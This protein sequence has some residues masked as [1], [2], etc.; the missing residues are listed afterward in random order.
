MAKYLLRNV[1]FC[2][3]EREL[4]E[5]SNNTRICNVFSEISTIFFIMHK[6]KSF[7]ALVF[8]ALVNLLVRANKTTFHH[9]FHALSPLFPRFLPNILQIP[10]SLCCFH[11]HCCFCCYYFTAPFYALI[12]HSLFPCSGSKCY[13]RLFQHSHHYNYYNVL[14]HSSSFQRRL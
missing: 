14:I 4:A 9:C 11:Q 5:C 2:I 6:K 12:V 13:P 3:R 1:H 8:V 10:L 7:S